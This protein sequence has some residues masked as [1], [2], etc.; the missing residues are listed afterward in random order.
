[1]V[2]LLWRAGQMSAAARLEA[3][4]NKLMSANGFSLFCAYPI[5]VFGG[6][7]QIPIV[8]EVLCAHTHLLPGSAG[9]RLDS[10]VNR[11]FDEILGQRA[12]GLRHLVKANFRPSWAAVPPAEA[13]ILWLRNN[14][15]EYA[16]QILTLARV[17]YEA[18]ANG[19]NVAENRE[20]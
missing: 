9:G 10:A 15:P 2:G 12:D 17:Y 3:F 11:A 6:E 20:N 7:F 18:S 19:G 4:W 5:D 14:L 8:D 16:D 13:T 1:M